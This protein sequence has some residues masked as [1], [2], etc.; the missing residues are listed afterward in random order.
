MRITNLKFLFLTLFI[1]VSP[2]FSNITGISAGNNHTLMLIDDGSVYSW[3]S[4]EYGQLGDS[5][6]S[7]RHS[8]N[9]VRNITDTGY[10]MDIIDV[11]AGVNYSLA[12]MSDGHVLAFGK[13]DKGQLG[14]GTSSDARFPCYVLDSTGYPIEDIEKISAGS[15]HS[16]ALDSWGILWAWG[17]NNE[18]QLGRGLADSDAHTLAY[19]VLISSSVIFNGVDEMVAGASFNLAMRFDEMLWSWGSGVDGQLGNDTTLSRYFPLPV[20][21][22]TG[23]DTLKNISAFSA[24]QHGIFGITGHS[25]A[26]DSYG[27]LWGWGRNFNGQLA[28]ASIISKRLPT[29]VLNGSGFGF[30][31]G[32]TA[33]ES[34]LEH[35]IALLDDG[36]VWAWGNNFYG[37]IGNN[38]TCDEHLPVRVH[39]KDNIGYLFDAVKIE[40]GSGHNFVVLSDS[41]LLAWGRN[42][43]GQ[44][45]DGTTIQ[46]NFPVEIISI[47][48]TVNEKSYRPAQISVCAYPNPFNSSLR[49]SIEA[50]IR[51]IR[52]LP[53]NIEVFDISGRSVVDL[54]KNETAPSKL[55][56][57]SNTKRT[58]DAEA[59]YIICKFTWTP[60]ASISSGVYLIRAKMG[61]NTSITKR[62]IFIK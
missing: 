60:N 20:F 3:G 46:H 18:G 31:L 21:D 10:L 33:F 42:G 30:L 1:Y 37:S 34:G 4:N 24:T 7:E 47:P 57:T 23:T 54:T 8:P 62:V 2:A 38:S 58:G 59:A 35:S 44:L 49:V 29:R 16:L 48:V 40:T 5:L 12:L 11:S 9:R 53:F 55:A 28:D 14:N 56:S 15:S 22:S 36:S 50:P 6:I 43:Y 26:L 27:K 25:L 41:R 52:E 19:P 45:G 17:T 13:N 39:G 51:A 61:F 32:V